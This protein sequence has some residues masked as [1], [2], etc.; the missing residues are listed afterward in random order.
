MSL[1]LLL[2]YLSCIDILWLT[3][4]QKSQLPLI[5]ATAFL[6][7]LGMSLFI[8]LLPSIIAGFSVDPSWTGYTQAVYAVGMFI[9][10]LIFWRLSDRYGR[11][12][13]LAFTSI[14]NLVSYVIMLISI[15]T[16]TINTSGNISHSEVGIIGGSHF[17]SAFAWWTPLFLIFLLA[18]LVGWLGGAGFSVIQ[19]YIA[20]ISSPTER[21]KN[22]GFMGAAFGIAF[23]IGPALSGVLSNFISSRDIIMITFF[24]ILLNVIL[25]YIFLQEPKK[26]IHTEEVHIVD[27][28]FSRM[29]LT[30]LFLSFG[31]TLAFAAIQAMS[32]Q[33]YAD[34]FSFSAV[35]IGYTMA[36]VGLVAVIYQAWLVK[37]VR[38]YLDEYQMLTFAFVVLI[39]GFAWF[40]FNESPYWLFFWVIFFPLGM[41]SFNPAVG[42]LL[43]KTAG[44]EV[45]KVMGYNTSIQSI[46]QI[47]WPI[48]AW[49][50]YITPGTNVPFLASTAIFVVLF[51]V[52]LAI[53][54]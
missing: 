15:W 32:T 39:I 10:G 45:W 30:L 42:S 24:V 26:H 46:W 23:L 18:R 27:F 21:M 43:A 53:K 9:W 8:P 35:Q 49:L 50:L 48:L 28:H 25:I 33:F 12:R 5:L 6:D 7:I 2:A 14:I 11:K 34:R 54:K 37:Y 31:S 36:M 1:W 22:M 40:S 13:M 52:S 44:K 38:K 4:T 17:L 16:L 51:W 41:G 47:A 19:A 29:V 20:D 3:M